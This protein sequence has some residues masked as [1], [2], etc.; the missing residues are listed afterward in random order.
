MEQ[1][2][3]AHRGQ[4]QGS[5]LAAERRRHAPLSHCQARA[6]QCQGRIRRR[7]AGAPPPRLL[8]PRLRRRHRRPA[9]GRSRTARRPHRPF[10]AAGRRRT[11]HRR[12][13]HRGGH[14]RLRE[15]PGRSAPRHPQRGLC[16]PRGGPGLPLLRPWRRAPSGEAGVRPRGPS[17]HPAAHPARPLRG[18]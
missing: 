10:A 3:A 14:R 2:A 17:L 7:H 8:R 16:I 13:R 11:R 4:G 9:A 18:L 6:R 5:H 12:H 15:P 1:L